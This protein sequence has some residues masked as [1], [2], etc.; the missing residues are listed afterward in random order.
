M[1]NKASIFN[2]T[3]TKGEEEERKGQEKGEGTGIFAAPRIWF[4]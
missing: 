4:S 3:T 1:K 2:T